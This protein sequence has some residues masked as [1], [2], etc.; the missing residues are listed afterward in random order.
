MDEDFALTTAKEWR[1]EPY[2]AIN[3][4]LPI[5]YATLAIAEATIIPGRWSKVRPLDLTTM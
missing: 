5:E 4:K 2:L 3:T 1:F